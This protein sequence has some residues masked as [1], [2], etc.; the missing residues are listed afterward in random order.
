MKTS[1]GRW[2]SWGALGGAAVLV[3]AAAAGR[4]NHRSGGLVVL[5]DLLDHGLG[6]MTSALVLFLVAMVLLRWNVWVR[7]VLAGLAGCLLLLSV[8]VWIMAEDA[9]AEIR[10]EPAPGRPDRRLVVEEGRAMIDPFWYVSVDEGSGLTT[11]RWHV[12]FVDGDWNSLREVSW[13]SADRLRVVTGTESHLILISES[14]RPD[15]TV[16]DGH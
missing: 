12:A 6:F 10:S 7:T 4:V 5:R 8:P 15:R 1:W 9:P 14:G 11:R 2:V 13:E 3:G 16:D